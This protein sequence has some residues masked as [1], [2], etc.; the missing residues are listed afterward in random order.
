MQVQKTIAGLVVA[1]LGI[2]VSLVGGASSQ[3]LSVALYF[4][5]ISGQAINPKY[6]AC[7]DSSLAGPFLSAGSAIEWRDEIISD[8]VAIISH[9]NNEPNVCTGPPLMHDQTSG[10]Y[11]YN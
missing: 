11:R 6:Y 4:V 10:W 3:D 5:D 7:N 1:T 2:L 8:G 9:W